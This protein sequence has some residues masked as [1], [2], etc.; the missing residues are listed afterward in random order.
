[1]I[2][3]VIPVAGRGTRLL[4]ATKS[5]PKEMLPLVDRPALFYTVQEAVE[6][7]ATEIIFITSRHKPSIEHFFN[8][9]PELESLLEKKG[10]EKALHEIRKVTSLA[11]YHFIYQEEPLGLG[12]AVGLA[13]NLVGQNPFLVLLPDELLLSAPSVSQSLVQSF[14]KT[15]QSQTAIMWVSREDTS[16]YGIIE[17]EKRGDLF[18]IHNVVEKPCA[19][20]APSQWALPGRYL[21]TPE[22]FDDL[23]NLSPGRGGEI[24]L[25]D[26][27]TKL[28]QKRGL[29]GLPTTARRIDTGNPLGYLKA[30]VEMAL[31]RPE[32]KEPFLK[33]LSD[34]QKRHP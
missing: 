31:Q 28:A 15:N 18:Y 8:P 34:Y 25:T 5:V 10:Q 27:M 13:K 4:P 7:G 2:K 16:K 6:A 12:H 22:I 14:Q 11:S 20:E 17:G 29:W 30:Q 1:M 23:E 9:D 26:A 19:E 32:L 3:A 24:Q 33:Y 21:F